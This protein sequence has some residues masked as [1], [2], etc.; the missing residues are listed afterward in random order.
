MTNCKTRIISAGLFLAFATPILQITGCAPDPRNHYLR[1][2]EATISS[3]PLV[4][5]VNRH[6]D[7]ESVTFALRAEYR[8]PSQLDIPIRAVTETQPDPGSRLFR[9]R[10]KVDQSPVGVGFELRENSHQIIDWFVTGSANADTK[11][12][13][14]LLAGAGLTLPFPFINLRAAPAVGFHTYTL[15]TEDSTIIQRTNI[16]T[17]GTYKDTLIYRQKNKS[18]NFGTLRSISVSMWPPKNPERPWTPYFQYQA[19]WLGMSAND[20]D[21]S[22]PK[23]IIELRGQTLA[24]GLDYA[25]GKT[26]VVNTRL[27]RESM[28]NHFGSDAYYR[29]ESGFGM[30]LSTEGH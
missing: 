16:F 9:S 21:N 1:T 24:V 6:D 26:F 27:S 4:P 20:S 19:H 2:A 11:I 15:R 3:I 14:A 30:R 28:N 29:I 22:V 5:A 17:N 23:K 25:V 8:T 18:P 10:Y 7:N 13:G 12:R